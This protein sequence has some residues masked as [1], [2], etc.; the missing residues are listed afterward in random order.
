MKLGGTQNCIF[1]KGVLKSKIS[2]F[3]YGSKVFYIL[4]MNVYIFTTKYFLINIL[5]KLLHH[6][7]QI[8]GECEG[9]GRKLNP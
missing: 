5:R 7:V 9:E 3:Y 4:H 8:S 2:A 1:G 6:V